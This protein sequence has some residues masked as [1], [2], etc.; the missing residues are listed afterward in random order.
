VKVVLWLSIGAMLGWVASLI[1]VTE[2]RQGV[3][4]NLLMGI[5]GALF[6]GWIIAPLIAGAALHDGG[7][8]VIGLIASFTCAAA[9]LAIVNLM[10]FK[11]L[12]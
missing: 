12:R 3:I 8:K 6:G 10:D 11:I 7:F 5:V 9:V 2:Q 1:M 4:M